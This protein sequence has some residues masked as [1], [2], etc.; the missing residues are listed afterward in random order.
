MQ[1]NSKQD[2]AKSLLQYLPKTANSLQKLVDY[3]QKV[4]NGEKMDEKVIDDIL[5]EIIIVHGNIRAVANSIDF[6]S[7]DTTDVDQEV[8]KTYFNSIYQL[9]D[10]IK[11]MLEWMKSEREPDESLKKAVNLLFESGQKIIWVVDKITES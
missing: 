9:L 6:K 10:G 4:I 11:I 5:K 8:I 1:K 7:I 2:I 3:I